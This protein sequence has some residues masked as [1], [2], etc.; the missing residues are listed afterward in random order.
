MHRGRT[1]HKQVDKCCAFG[2]LAVVPHPQC[3]GLFSISVALASSS[4]NRHHLYRSAVTPGSS[5][6]STEKEASHEFDNCAP[7]WNGLWVIRWRSARA[8]KLLRAPERIP[9]FRLRPLHGGIYGS[10]RST[11]HDCCCCCLVES[12]QK[13]SAQL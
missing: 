3:S 5:I 1:R 6:D 9:I 8:V 10:A 12:C 7:G 4:S 13:H 11:Q 2:L